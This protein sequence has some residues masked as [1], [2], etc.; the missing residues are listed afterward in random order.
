MS[1]LYLKTS[2]PVSRNT[3]RSSLNGLQN[4]LRKK[5]S[6]NFRGY[7]ILSILKCHQNSLQKKRISLNSLS[8]KSNFTFS[9]LVDLW[10]TVRNEYTTLNSKAI[11]IPLPFAT[12]YLCETRFTTVVVIKSKCRSNTNV[13]LQSHSSHLIFSYFSLI[14]IYSCDQLNIHVS[15]RLW[16]FSFLC[17]ITIMSIYSHVQSNVLICY[18]VVGRF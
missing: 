9:H 4:S 15:L 1:T 17:L 16:L 10:I 14:R 2:C 18:Y 6:R 12:S 5:M 13:A 11:R 7:K 8:L 3:F